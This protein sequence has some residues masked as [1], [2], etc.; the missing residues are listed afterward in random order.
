MD[1]DGDD[2]V[3]VAGAGT[4]AASCWPGAIIS[5]GDCGDGRCPAARSAQ[6][7]PG[8]VAVGAGAGAGAT[9]DSADSSADAMR[10]SVLVFPATA[11]SSARLSGVST[12]FRAP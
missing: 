4:G 8:R 6:E 12:A 10:H 7:A 11:C 5:G 1:S 3:A 9:A 2:S